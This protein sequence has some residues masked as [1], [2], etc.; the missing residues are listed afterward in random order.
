[1]RMLVYTLLQIK[2][3]RS[4]NLPSLSTTS[5]R[6]HRNSASRHSSPHCCLCCWSSLPLI[7]LQ[8]IQGRAPTMDSGSAILW[9]RT[10]APLEELARPLVVAS[11]DTVCTLPS[12][13][14]SNYDHGSRRGPCSA[15]QSRIEAS[16]VQL[17]TA[18]DALLECG[19]ARDSNL[20][21]AYP[22]VRSAP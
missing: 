14:L 10:R 21:C 2:L 3:P 20:E 8:Q 9:P 6:G 12:G 19:R 18:A 5:Q 4:M 1:M 16:A 11:A 22:R 17:S 15:C 13:D 7:E